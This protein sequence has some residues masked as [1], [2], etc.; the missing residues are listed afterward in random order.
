LDYPARRESVVSP[1][2]QKP[3][4]SS[5]PLTGRVPLP[6]LP[7]ASVAGS[8]PTRP[9]APSAT[10]PVSSGAAPTARPPSRPS[11]MDS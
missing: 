9:A 6:A 2:S 7:P 11:G 5:Q 4:H 3:L 1:I 10:C 8:T